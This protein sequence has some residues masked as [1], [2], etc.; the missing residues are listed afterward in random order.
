MVFGT[1]EANF[2]LY[3][4]TADT[5]PLLMDFM[6]NI[7][8]GSRVISTLADIDNDGYYEMAV[9]ND[10]GGLAFYNTIFKVDT[11]SS[12]EED[13]GEIVPITLFPNPAHNEIYI[14]TTLDLGE[15]TL[16]NVQGQ[17]I[18]S[19]QNNASNQLP[20]DLNS[21]L[22]IIKMKHASGTFSRKLLIQK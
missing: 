2:R 9:G 12:T 6:G 17:Q 19:L 16:Y 11:T 8:E 13:M 14:F 3:E 4:V 10:R 7:K 15:I 21:G 18:M 22:Y 5:F 20:L 1:N